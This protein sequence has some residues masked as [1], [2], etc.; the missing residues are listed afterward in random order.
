MKKYTVE[1]FQTNFDYLMGRVENG[2]SYIIK[3]DNGDVAVIPYK[4]SQYA[5]DCED[6]VKIHMDHEEGC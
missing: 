5:L 1:E 3:S 4:E 2:E 6:I